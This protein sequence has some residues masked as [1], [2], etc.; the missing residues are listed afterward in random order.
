MDY[1]VD[2]LVEALED[3]DE[4]SDKD[5]IFEIQQTLESDEIN[6]SVLIGSKTSRNPK[7]EDVLEEQ[8][9]EEELTELGKLLVSQADS[10]V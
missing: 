8:S 9:N 3:L 2:K 5:E 1:N 10:D 4:N 7:L 6:E